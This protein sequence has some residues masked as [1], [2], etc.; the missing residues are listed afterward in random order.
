[1]ADK[2]GFLLSK[3]VDFSPKKVEKVDSLK[4]RVRNSRFFHPKNVKKEDFFSKKWSK[5]LD[6]FY[7]KKWNFLQKRSKKWIVIKKGSEIADF[8]NQKR[9]KK[10]I[11]SP[12][13]GQK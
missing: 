7:Q 12:K 1:M 2:T 10:W 11:F 8:F 5:K 4:K 6:F 9:S 13:N 3:K